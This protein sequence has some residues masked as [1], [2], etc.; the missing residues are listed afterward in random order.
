MK[1]I[2][3]GATTNISRYGGGSVTSASPRWTQVRQL[4]SVR[5]RHE[6]LVHRAARESGGSGS[7][8]D[9]A[10]SRLLGKL[11]AALPQ[12][13]HEP[14]NGARE[15]RAACGGQCHVRRWRPTQHPRNLDE[16]PPVHERR[17][18]RHEDGADRHTPRAVT[19]P[20]A[21]WLRHPRGCRGEYSWILSRYTCVAHASNA[22]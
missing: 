16:H 13:R 14:P 1:P 5:S 4:L 21:V 22:H 6:R 3:R 12:R 17:E 19:C 8:R 9:P 2:Q 15:R 11:V 10:C 18:K 20:S 7:A